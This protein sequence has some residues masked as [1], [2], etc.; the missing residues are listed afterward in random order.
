VFERAKAVHASDSAATVIGIMLYTQVKI[1]RRFGETKVL[2][3][4]CFMLGFLTGL[5]ID[6]EDVD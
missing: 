1:I 3:A 4:P 2:F 6:P 5:L